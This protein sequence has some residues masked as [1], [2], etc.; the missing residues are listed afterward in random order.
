[1]AG[2]LARIASGPLARQVA[3]GV[4]GYV[5]YSLLDGAIE[6]V[7]EWLDNQEWKSSRR[8]R[9][10]DLPAPVGTSVIAPT[11]GVIIG[12]QESDEAGLQ[13]FLAGPRAARG[14][15]SDA[16]R[17]PRKSVW[18]APGSLE[19]GRDEMG[20]DDSGWRFGFAHLDGIN[21][22]DR[23][24]VARGQQIATTGNSGTASTGPHLH[25]TSFWVQD[26]IADVHTFVDP[27][28][29]IPGIPPSVPT[30]PIGPGAYVTVCLLVRPSSGMQAMTKCV[31]QTLP[32]GLGLNWAATVQGVK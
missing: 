16:N 13:L 29:L 23:M 10:L 18:F 20:V 27:A 8:H 3:R 24:V 9:G 32:T 1:M 2:A 15:T 4:A 30:S 22:Q 31:V 21:V 17:W 19:A 25:L 7:Q 14:S 11:E 26:G 28:L 5:G 12:R 6:R